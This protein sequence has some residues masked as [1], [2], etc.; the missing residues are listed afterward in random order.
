MAQ[1][2]CC[3]TLN[4]ITSPYAMACGIPQGAG[5]VDNIGA[6]FFPATQCLLGKQG[7]RLQRASFSSRMAQGLEYRGPRRTDGEGGVDETDVGIG[8]GKVSELGV[9]FRHKM[10][11]EEPQMV[12][13]CEHLR[14]NLLSFREPS[15]SRESLHDPKGADD[16]A[17]LR[18]AEI[19]GPQV[20]KIKPGVFPAGLHREPARDAVHRGLTHLP[21]GKAKDRRLGQGGIVGV[22]LGAVAEGAIFGCVQERLRCARAG[23]ADIECQRGQ[24]SR[25]LHAVCP[26]EPGPTHQIG[27]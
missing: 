1:G 26:V 13:A 23:R 8:L 16:K 21:V 7:L 18:P 10:L 11:R 24:E 22:V 2:Q 3:R 20:P 15:E 5:I 27:K 9:G 17:G 6:S 4:Q 12:R 19:V 25:L 14:H